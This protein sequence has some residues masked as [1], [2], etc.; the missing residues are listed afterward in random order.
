MSE[1]S[2]SQQAAPSGDV[3]Q[4]QGKPWW[5]FPILWLVVGGP[6]AVVIASLATVVVAVKHVD[7]VLQVDN[8]GNKS[9]V[10]A[11]QGRNHAA[12]SSAT[13]PAER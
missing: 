9:T 11:I 8:T 7:P 12:E 2:S 10:P 5:R 4:D 1:V 6:L 13:Q 3:H